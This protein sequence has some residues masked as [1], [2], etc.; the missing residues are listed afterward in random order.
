MTKSAAARDDRG[1][2]DAA[3][4]DV[5]GAQVLDLLLGLVADSL[6]HRHQPDDGGHA[7]QDAQ[8]GQRRA[9]LVQQQA[10]EAQ[11]Q[12]LPESRVHGGRFRVECACSGCQPRLITWRCRCRLTGGGP[13]ATSPIAPSVGAAS[14]S[15]HVSGAKPAQSG[16]RGIHPHSKHVAAAASAAAAGSGTTARLTSEPRMSK[17]GMIGKPSS[18]TSCGSRSG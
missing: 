17:D 15:G 14:S 13:A 9:Q 5:V 8:H 12:R 1:R 6:A 11:S 3:H 4:D 16:Q 18:S 2:L 10:L 7:D